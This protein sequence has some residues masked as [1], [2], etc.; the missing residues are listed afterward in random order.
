MG[1]SLAGPRTG[2]GGC[3]DLRE[4]LLGV[5]PGD[6]LFWV[7]DVGGDPLYDKEHGG[8]HHRVAQRIMGQLTRQRANGSWSHL[9]LT[10]AMNIAGT[11]GGAEALGMGEAD[12]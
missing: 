8:F 12:G 9:P 2:G 11:R 6:T 3:T 4:I 7:R 1:R 10:G 5:S